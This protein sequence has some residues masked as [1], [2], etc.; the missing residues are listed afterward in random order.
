MGNDNQIKINFKNAKDKNKASFN[1]AFNDETTFNDALDYISYNFPQ[2]Y[3]CPCFDFQYY[4]G[5]ELSKID[6]N[7][8][9]IDLNK[10]EVTIN[11][12]NCKCSKILKNILKNLKLK[13]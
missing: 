11:Y 9:I 7:S 13:L 6:K 8:K 3:I 1:L 12:Q 4:K 10:S 5:S 2:Y